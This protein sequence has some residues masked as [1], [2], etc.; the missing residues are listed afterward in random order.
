[1]AMEYSAA[2]NPVRFAVLGSQSVDPEELVE[3]KQ[4]EAHWESA[5][6]SQT[7]P[8]ADPEVYSIPQLMV[9]SMTGLTAAIGCFLSWMENSF[10][11]LILVVQK[12]CL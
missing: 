3:M 10:R 7:H 8:A 9:S 11:L 5:Q 12:T 2:S 6:G 4:L 1:M